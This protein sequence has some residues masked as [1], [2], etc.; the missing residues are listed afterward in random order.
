MKYYYEYE[1]AIDKLKF[2]A[3]IR[4]EFIQYLKNDRFRFQSFVPCD[5]ENKIHEI[6]TIIQHKPEYKT[7]RD[8]Y[9][10][11]MDSL[12][13]EG[14]I[15]KLRIEKVLSHRNLFWRGVAK[16][17]YTQIKIKYLIKGNLK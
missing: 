9:E 6:N 16:M 13:I 7:Y 2:K 8:I 11:Y 15:V 1:I 12:I 3:K 14:E 10:P 5:K 17:K 4:D